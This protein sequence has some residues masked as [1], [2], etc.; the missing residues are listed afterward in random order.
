[1]CSSL[2]IRYHAIEIT[3]IVIIMPHYSENQM[4][5]ESFHTANNLNRGKSDSKMLFSE[6]N[7]TNN[8]LCLKTS[9]KVLSPSYLFMNLWTT[10]SRKYMLLQAIHCLTTQGDGPGLKGC[11]LCVQ[12]ERVIKRV[13]YQSLWYTLYVQEKIVVES[14]TIFVIPCCLFVCRKRLWLKAAQ[15]L[16]LPII[17]VYVQ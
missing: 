6:S 14:C 7:I 11:F 4:W 17:Y 9:V 5:K 12:D 13:Q 10:K 1:M 15:C 16:S 3:T 8:C 2:T